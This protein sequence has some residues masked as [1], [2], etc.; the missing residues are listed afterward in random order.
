MLSI[1]EART[2]GDILDARRLLQEYA[3][4]LDI[5]ND[6]S[7]QHFENE[8]DTL[9]GQYAAPEGRLLL[10]SWDDQ[11]AGC[12][13]L[14]PLG[15]GTCEMKRLY[16]R[17]DFRSRGVGGLLIRQIIEAAGDAGYHTLRLDSLPTMHAAIRLYRHLG[18]REI[19]PYH[20]NSG[21]GTVF[22]EL[23]LKGQD[24]DA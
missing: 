9:P 23:P 3:S 18:F 5:T 7:F 21:A 14:R 2:G 16:V 13:A 8:L 10:A 19:L 4:S 12:V 6:L 17:P 20:N 11:P 1:A 24:S 15:G 22:L